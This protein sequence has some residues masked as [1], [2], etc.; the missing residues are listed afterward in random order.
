MSFRVVSEFLRNAGHEAVVDNHERQNEIALSDGALGHAMVLIRCEA[1]SYPRLLEV[2]P[3]LITHEAIEAYNRS[4]VSIGS[5]EDF[6]QALQQAIDE[7]WARL[8]HMATIVT[9]HFLGRDDYIQARA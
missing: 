4:P 3:V 6:T 7:D 1:P 8:F 9:P 5:G 2:K